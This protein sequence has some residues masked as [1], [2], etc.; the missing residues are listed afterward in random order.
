MR[1]PYMPEYFVRKKRLKDKSTELV[2]K[3]VGFTGMCVELSIR[4]L[5]FSVT[6][7]ESSKEL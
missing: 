1:I 5:K 6:S 7:D 4:R 2:S 3:V